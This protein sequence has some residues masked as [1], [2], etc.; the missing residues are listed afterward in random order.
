MLK[1]V[2][3]RDYQEQILKELSYVPAIGLFM[4]TGSGKTITSLERF[5][6]NPTPHLLII[7]PQKIITQ[8]EEV[9][10]KHTDLSVCKY[11]LSWGSNKKNDVINDFLLKDHI[12]NKCVVVNFDIISKMGCFDWAINE[13]W[14]II[15]DESHKI[16]NMGTARS[17]VKTTKKVLELGELTPY[18]IILTATPTEKEYGGY[19]DFYAQLRFLGYI[20]Y[21]E[22]YFKNRFCKIQKMQL[23]GMPFPINKITGYHMNLVDKELKP[24]IKYSCRYFAPKYGDYEPEF[25]KVDIPRCTNYPKMLK[26]RTYKEITFDN[27]S[28]FRIGKKTLTAGVVTGTDEYGDRYTYGDNTNK[29]DWLEE[30]ISNTDD[31]IS[32][33]YNYNIERDIIISL[34]EKL[35]KKYV[36]IDGSVKDKP[37]E[38]KKDFD[39]LIGQYEA[40]GESLDG[41]Q[42]KCHLMVFYSM[43]DSSRAYRQSLGRIDRIGQTDMPVYYHLVMASTIDDKIYEMTQ[44]KVE[45]SER[46]LNELTV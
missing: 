24:L 19:I 13:D 2:E 26:D 18:K 31:V 16:K 33:L 5:T 45:F 1:G 3:L 17:P 43:P 39:I 34:C 15:V 21:S 40:F 30:F 35:K 22:T 46:D 27:V 14:T 23:P 7:C 11:N 9:I 36:V 28:A 25:I 37:A 8:W 20:D 41:L 4:K 12:A 42:F 32:V 6:R 10:E 38:L 29:R 44:N